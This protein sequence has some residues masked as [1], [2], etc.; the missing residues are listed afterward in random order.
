MREKISANGLTLYCLLSQAKSLNERNL[1]DLPSADAL[2]TVIDEHLK[3]DAF[4]VAY[5]DYRVI[6]GRYTNKMFEFYPL[7]NGEQ[8]TPKYLQKLRIFNQNEELLF[9][10]SGQMLK[11]RHRKDGEGEEMQVIEAH[12]VL[13]GT[14]KGKHSNETFTEITEDRGTSLILPFTGFALN[15][16]TQRIFLKTHNYI[17]YNA[18]HQATYVDCRFVGFAEKQGDHHQN[19]L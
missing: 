18:V 14:K 19:L 4:F 12:Q 5:M 8:I 16:A 11:G 9:W 2:I 15:D 1:A 10:R 7:T 3:K 13:F 6:I 17:G